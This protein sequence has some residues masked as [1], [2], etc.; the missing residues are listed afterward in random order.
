VLEE[1]SDG[2]KIAEEDLRRRGPGNV[3]GHAQSGQA[4]LRFAELLADTRLV[5]LARALAE[6]TLDEDPALSLPAHLKLREFA[7]EAVEAPKEM[8]Q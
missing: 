8:L 4:P 1:T 5:R 6:R 2:F 3:L 7:F